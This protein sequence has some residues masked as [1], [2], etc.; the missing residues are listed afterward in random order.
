M[1]GKEAVFVGKLEGFENYVVH[2]RVRGDS[3]LHGMLMVGPTC[4]WEGNILADV[5]IV[6]GLVQGNVTARQ[7]VEL[8][9]TARVS[10]LV[11]APV[12]AVGEGAV[13]Q[14]GMAPEA[15]ITHFVERRYQ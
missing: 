8:R 6:K 1:V 3:D 14:G 5:V 9:S 13:V 10:G 7:K 2:G 11:R 15:A 12:V 4:Q